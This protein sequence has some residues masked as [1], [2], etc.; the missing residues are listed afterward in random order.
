MKQ[1]WRDAAPILAYDDADV[2]VIFQ[3][4]GSDVL[5]VTFGDAL[6][7]A[8]GLRFAA[9]GLVRKHGF[10]CLGFMAHQA[11]W[12]PADALARALPHIAYTLGSFRRILAY[13]CSMGAYAAI[14][15]AAVLGATDVLA[16]GPQWSID[17][18]ECAFDCGYHG[19]FT[20]RMAGMGIRTDD[21]AGRVA[22]LYDRGHALDRH[23]A[24]AIAALGPSVARIHVPSA[25][26]HLAP[27]LAGSETTAG[28]MQ[29]WLQDDTAALYRLLAARRRP[30]PVRVRVLLARAVR[31]HPAMALAAIR[32]LARTGR[33][34]L[35]EAELHLIPLLQTLLAQGRADLAVQA[36]DAAADILPPIHARIL[37]QDFESA[38]PVSVP[39]WAILTAHGTTLF[40]DSV[41]GTLRHR[42]APVPAAEAFGLHPATLAP[43]AP[44]AAPL[45]VPIRGTTMACTRAGNRLELVHAPP[46]G[47]ACVRA[48]RRDPARFTLAV[49]ANYLCASPDGQVFCDRTE[50]NA[51]EIF[52]IV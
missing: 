13:G 35:V 24:D 51:W 42:A 12:F 49:E 43:H 14:K 34:G 8:D 15:H 47:A 52:A 29:A 22:L 16:L 11:N 37:R 26:H 32:L 17:P 9:D 28:L 50:A 48:A 25:D 5:L 40:Y 6:A 21:L 27:M 2:R 45:L 44:D 1:R 33:L 36:F 46:P 23:H 39:E 30:S 4:G 20:P 38:G 19:F 3:P 7:L 31:R 10:A 41:L 18:A